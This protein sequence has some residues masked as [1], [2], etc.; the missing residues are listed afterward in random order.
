M[1]KPS[2]DTQTILKAALELIEDPGPGAFSARRL[3]ARLRCSTRTLY[4]Q[5]GKQEDLIAA[6]LNHHFVHS[7]PDL[8]TDAPWQEQIDRWAHHLRDAILSRPQLAKHLTPE[9]RPALIEFT[10]P[11]L[12]TLVDQGFA[13]ETG[14]EVC[15]SVAYVVIS[16]TLGE[17]ATQQHRYTEPTESDNPLTHLLM[18]GANQTERS[19]DG[20]APPP[21]FEQT[22]RWLISGIAA[23]RASD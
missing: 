17:V 16:L 20:S 13:A 19:P 14:V 7:T 3:A 12:E 10:K 2:V 15:R 8:A 22:V 11:L 4:E 18:V 23:D 5:V 9:N 6:L 21:V 1:P